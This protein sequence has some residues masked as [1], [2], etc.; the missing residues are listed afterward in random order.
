MNIV[1]IGDSIFDNASYVGQAESVSD[2]L[3]REVSESKV[4]LLAVDGDITTDVHEQLKSF[5]ADATHVFI[6]CGGND[7]LINDGVLEDKCATVDEAL[8][9]LHDIKEQFRHNYIAMLEAVQS[10][11]SRIAACTI[12]NKVPGLNG[13]K[14]T[15]LALFNEIILEVLSSKEL[16]ILD[17]RVICN[18][19][20]DYSTI[21]PIETSVNGG[22]KIVSRMITLMETD[23]SPKI[24]V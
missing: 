21:S 19:D 7:A 8:Q 12:Y 13:S 2:I 15:A 4:S 17:L 6:S 5:P 11:H 23:F 18:E 10:K 14:N 3:K 16:P 1:L 24:Y 9:L 20:S 22:R